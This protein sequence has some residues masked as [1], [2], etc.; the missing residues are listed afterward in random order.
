MCGDRRIE[1]ISTPGGETIDSL[2]VWLPDEGV[3]L[4]GNCSRPCS[5][6]FRTS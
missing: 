3:A 1:L 2:V 6:T 5:A 4:A